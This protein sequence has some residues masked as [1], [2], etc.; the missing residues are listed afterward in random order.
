MHPEN[1]FPLVDKEK[2]AV[3]WCKYVDG[4]RILPK[5]PVHIRLHKT[6]FELNQL[7]KEYIFRTREGQVFDE[8]NT[9]LKLD[10]ESSHSIP[11]PEPLPVIQCQAMH[12]NQ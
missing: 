5:L 2:S 11:D 3:E 10:Q 9:A 7:V 4:V 8:L 12:G 6:K 1:D